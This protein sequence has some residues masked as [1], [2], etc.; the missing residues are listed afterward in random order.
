MYIYEKEPYALRPVLEADLPGL[1]A[2]RNDPDTWHYLTSIFP[3]WPHR[4]HQ[5]LDSV[6]NKNMYFI[7]TY[8]TKDVGL[9][10]VTEIDWINRNSCIGVDIFKHFRAQGHGTATFSLLVSYC[11]EVLGLHRVWLLVAEPN[12]AAKI[13]YEKEGF[14]YEGVMKEHLYR[15]GRYIDYL[16]MGLLRDQWKT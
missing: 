8:G 9:A 15:D 2:H 4:Q 5:W 16:L 10:R 3:V 7:S 12:D 1:A 6:D 11:F 13:I 14:Q